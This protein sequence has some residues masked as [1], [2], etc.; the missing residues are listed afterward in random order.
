M[1]LFSKKNEKKNSEI[2]KLPELPSLPPTLPDFRDYDESEVH[3]LPSFPNS[4]MGDKFSRESIKNAVSGEDEDYEDEEPQIKEEDL[5]PLPKFNKIQKPETK[6]I[7]MDLPLRVMPKERVI[8][9]EPVFVQIERFEEALHVFRETREKI[10]EIE[11]L[12]EE[13][14]SLKEKEESELSTWED[15]I[16]EMKE[17]IEKV[18]KDIFSKV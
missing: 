11:K 15:E 13:T 2:P 16:Q 6:K 1:G 9:S 12:L 18:D 5:M 14:K 17:K 7:K 8:E 4:S 10:D 3:E